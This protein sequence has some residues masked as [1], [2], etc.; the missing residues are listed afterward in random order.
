M[1]PQFF[2]SLPPP[3]AALASAPPPYSSFSFP[4]PLFYDYVHYSLSFNLKYLFIKHSEEDMVH[5]P[6]ILWAS[7]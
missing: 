4:I 6:V 3:P 1:Y 5:N 7:T 2:R